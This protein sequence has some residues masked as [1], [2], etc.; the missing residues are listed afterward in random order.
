MSLTAKVRDELRPGH[1]VL[2][3]GSSFGFLCGSDIDCVAFD[4]APAHPDVWRADFFALEFDPDLGTD[5]RGDGKDLVAV[6]ARV[7]R[8][9]RRPIEQN[10]LLNIR[11]PVKFCQNSGI[12]SQFFRNSENV[13]T[14]QHF[15]EYSAKS[16]QKIIKIAANFDEN[17]RK[18]M[19]FCENSNKNSKKS[20]EFLRVF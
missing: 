20:D 13:K 9:D 1:R 11:I 7:E 8:F 3:I 6:G 19:I 18:I 16:R 17:H 12:F 10:E 5:V 4:L 14:S 2:D 15:L